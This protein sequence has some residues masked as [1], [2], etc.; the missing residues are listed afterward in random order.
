MD[1][2]LR[3]AKSSSEIGLKVTELDGLEGQ[4]KYGQAH[5]GVSSLPFDVESWLTRLRLSIAGV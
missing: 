4:V 1:I 2:G 3:T 5:D